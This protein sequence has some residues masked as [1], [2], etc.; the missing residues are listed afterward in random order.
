MNTLIIAEKPSVA[1]RIA[2]ALGNGKEQ[3]KAGRD[4]IS[5]YEIDT[6][7]GTVYV[8]AAVGHLF[9]IRQ[10]DSER[11]YPVLNVEWAPSY[12]VGKKSEHTKDYLDTLKDIAKKCD[13]F[14]NACDFDIEGTV[15]G[16]NIIREVDKKSLKDSAMRMKF[17]TT[18]T[19]DLRESYGHLMPLDMSNFYAGEARHMLD[20]LWG[21]NLSR[22]LT[23]A[24]YGASMRQ[25]LSIGRVQ[26]PALA[27]V[28]EREKE[29]AKFKPE[30]FWR[31]IALINSVEFLNT[32]GDI[33]DK[34]V[35]NDAFEESKAKR[36]AAVVEDIEVKEQQTAPYPPFDLT[37]LQIEASRALHL[38]PSV[39]LALA[40][41]LYEKAYIS[42]PRTSSQKLPAALG[43]PRIISDIS[44]NPAYSQL[45][46]RLVSGKRYTPHEG[47]KTDEA[48]PAIFPTGD[49]PSGLAA[50]EA[51][52]YDMIVR[53]F[54]AC[55]A[56][57]AIVGR[58]KVTVAIGGEKYSASGATILKPGWLEFY[59]YAKIDEKMLPDFK[60]GARVSVSDVQ[61]QDLETQ[62]PRRYTKAGL[63]SELEKRN[64]GTK[65]TRAQVIDTL[66]KRRYVE[67]ATNIIV[68]NFGM[69]VYDTLAENASMIV[70][71]DT[72]RQ[73]EEDMEKISQNKIKEED[74]IEEGKRMLLD[75]LKQF[76]KNKEQ[77]ATNMRKGLRE[78]SILGKC[79]V[80]GGDLLVR[81]SRAGKQFVA[82]GNY[83][84]CT[85]TYSLP[86]NALILPTG[87][88][89]EYCHTPFIKVI[90]K[91]RR[92]F[93]MDLDPKCITKKDW[94]GYGEEA[95]AKAVSAKPEEPTAPQPVIHQQKKQQAK[96]KA[97]PKAKKKP[98][99]K[100]KK[101]DD[102]DVPAT[103]L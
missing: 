67:G 28:A 17:S 73:L 22:A 30:P 87:R 61:M 76:D 96:P 23:S 78:S 50:Q 84:K 45:A 51:R 21:I 3:R 41:S 25:M 1:N 70:E 48:H 53:R 42:Y 40:Q 83:P 65:A 32:K 72:T 69:S 58:T 55:F 20:W 10:S 9:T 81:R 43:L 35:A 103:T 71:V 16:T 6:S 31:I 38:D 11:G 5:Y 102:I 52:L 56:E 82:C 15:I 39:T 24:V 66:F 92:P 94:A 29:I 86:Q 85:N 63:I 79:P 98:A 4:K 91:G 54:L 27:I 93:E 80:D 19:Q 100:K 26:G 44:K 7:T 46:G 34:K 18:T 8:A 99:R 12:E 37:S 97:K 75:A 59:T 13:R 101:S 74:V 64:V 60:K 89:C 68:T 88:T 33:F 77:I 90:R 95:P 47:A 14:I 36:E 57:F 49:M 2:S 62:P